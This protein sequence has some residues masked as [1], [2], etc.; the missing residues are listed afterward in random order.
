LVPRFLAAE[1]LVRFAEA[2]AALRDLA[3]VVLRAA[4]FAFCDGFLET[5]RLAAAFRVDDFRAARSACDAL[6]AMSFTVSVN[7]SMIDLSLAMVPSSRL[8][9]VTSGRACGFQCEHRRVG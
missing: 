3:F 7:F 8:I 6:F 2:L 4:V 5:A 1:L 9:E